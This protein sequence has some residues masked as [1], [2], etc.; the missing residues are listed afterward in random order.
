MR[1]RCPHLR[2]AAGIAFKDMTARI[3]SSGFAEIVYQ[4]KFG[5]RGLES[6]RIGSIE[7]VQ[8]NEHAEEIV[9]ARTEKKAD[10]SALQFPVGTSP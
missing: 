5:G 7:R 3:C 1:N 6:C 4:D 2:D 8:S 9:A 10:Q